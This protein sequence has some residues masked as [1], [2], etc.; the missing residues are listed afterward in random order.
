MERIV[1][2]TV[3]DLRPTIV[4]KSDQLNAEQLLGGPMTITVTD[5]RIGSGEEQPVIVH[6]A[7]EDGRPYKPCKTM[8]KVLIHA[9]GADGR[10]WAGRSMTLYNDPA[11]KFG[12][13]D[14]GGIRISHMTD[15]ERDVRV[16]LTS[17]RGKKA[18]Y[19][20]RRLSSP[21]A[22]LLSTITGAAG[23]DALKEAFGAAYKAHKDPGLR[24]QLKSAYDAR[25]SALNAAEHKPPARDLAHF[26]AQIEQAAGTE[27]AALILDEARDVLSEA[28]HAE[29]CRV[30]SAKWGE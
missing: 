18:K 20:I 21:I 22:G 2:A 9:W 19:E 7:N 6:Y 3:E 28:D 11:V 4:P 17:T 12:G 14:V 26:S 13:E 25:L 16:S 24:A 15:I 1:N 8:R 10:K 29:L 23:I 27:P 30:F 5:V